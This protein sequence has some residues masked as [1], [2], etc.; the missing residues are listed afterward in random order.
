MTVTVTPGGRGESGTTTERR[1]QLA[2]LVLVALVLV[3]VVLATW[4]VSK[5][6]TAEDDL[7]DAQDK[8]ATYAAGP[9]A[10]DAAEDDLREMISYDYRHV[11]DEY[12]W[13]DRI[14]NA[15]LRSNIQ[16]QTRKLA[17][18]IKLSKVT[19]KGTIVNSA[20]NT[21]DENT[22]TVLAF[23]RQTLSSPLDKNVRVAEQWTTLKMTREDA[24]SPWLIDDMDIVNVPP[25]S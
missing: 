16:K 8:L 3:A 9:E 21:I 15:K 1:Y 20:Y 23:V 10:R 12:A 4:L 6:N 14:G 17:K 2:I 5:K 19:A 24:D 18:V 13:L 11:D 7:K 22:A 25:P